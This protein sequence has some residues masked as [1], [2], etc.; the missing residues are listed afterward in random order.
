M[1]AI[2]VY[3]TP[4]EAERELKRYD[5]HNIELNE[6][7]NDE[8]HK[9]KGN[10]SD[11]LNEL[12]SK[13]YYFVAELA[14]FPNEY[15]FSASSFLFEGQNGSSKD[16]SSLVQGVN[17]TIKRLNNTRPTIEAIFYT[18]QNHDEHNQVNGERSEGV[19]RVM[20]ILFEYPRSLGVFAGEAR[21]LTSQERKEFVRL[22]ESK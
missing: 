3:Q 12:K 8:Y 22:Y 1:V 5:E 7:Y 16:I 4:E 2:L 11:R 15:I 13:K 10:I 19:R 14:A 17:D 9:C 18:V 6:E 20:E 21:G